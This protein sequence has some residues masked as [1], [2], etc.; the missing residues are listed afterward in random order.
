MLTRRAVIAAAVA[1][2]GAALAR[3]L[4]ELERLYGPEEDR[5]G[6]GVIFSDL[7]RTHDGERVSFRGYMA[8]QL[9]AESA[10]FVLTDV[11]MAVCPFCDTE[12]EWP[13]NILAVYAKRV[14]TPPN[15]WEQ[16]EVDGVLRLGGFE[17]PD[18]GFLSMVRVEDA[19]FRIV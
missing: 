14:V 7:A 3:P 15:F 5:T 17:D 18:T 8:P 16:I 13:N 11:P 4:L 10:F 19:V 2:P 1:L 9:I 6:P 12:A